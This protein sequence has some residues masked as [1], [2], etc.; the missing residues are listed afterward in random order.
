MASFPFVF[1]FAPHYNLKILNIKPKILTRFLTR[2]FL[3]GVGLVLLV[4]C[5]IIFSIT[6]V[7]RLPSNDT[8]Y[9]AIA[10]SWVRLLEYIPMFLPLAVFMGTLLASFNLTQS[11][12]SIIIAS[13][14]RSPYQMAKPF[15]VAAAVIGIIAATVVNPYSVRLSNQNI[16][17]DNLTL[18]DNA[19]WLRESSDSGFIT[20]RAKNMRK[21]DDLLVFTDAVLFR[22][23]A[24]FHM[25]ERI[26]AK[27]IALSDKGLSAARAKVWDNAGK[28]KIINWGAQTRLN[29]QT[30]LDRYLK[31][32][33]V[34]FWQLPGFIKKMESIGI[35]VRGHWVQFWTL[36]FLP[37][38]MIAMATLGVTFSQTKQ[39]RNYSF[40]IQF[41]FGIVACF[42]LYF[43]VNVF[44]ALGATGSLPALLAV[45]VPPCIITAFA[46]M[47]IA[48][49]DNI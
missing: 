4:V 32:G 28:M 21:T 35:N 34:S 5:G 37:L 30:V 39:R 16:T 15:L 45:L 23:A 40:G 44:N 31:P 12:E 3:S 42:A 26:E 19:I 36:L 24:D 27:E 1:S 2:R 9:L 29:P 6:F 10:D 25:A 49:F 7:E 13:A 22:Q 11:S 38:T 8:A 20:M 17:A 48:R 14:G 18:V 33:Q 47:F 43:V 46:G 41:G